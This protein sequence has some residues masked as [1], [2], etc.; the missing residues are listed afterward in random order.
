HQTLQT[1]AR[2][3]EIPI[4]NALCD[5]YHPMQALADLY[6]LQEKLGTDQKFTISFVGDANNVSYSLIE[7]ALILGH[8]IRF[9]CPSGYNWVPQQLKA[10]S[11]LATEYGGSFF[12]TPDPAE[13]VMGADAVY[14]DAFVSMGEEHAYQ[15][16]IQHF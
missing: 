10:F 3:S 7:L 9:A 8:K 11:K 16:K 2:Y 15:D 6:T 14:T 12:Y 1:L 4:V 5:K 13:A